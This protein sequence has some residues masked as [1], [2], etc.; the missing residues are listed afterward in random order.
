MFR[1]DKC[2]QPGVILETCRGRAAQES[3]ANNKMVSLASLF[4]SHPGFEM[5]ST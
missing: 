4:N 5:A 1:L 2:P 3:V